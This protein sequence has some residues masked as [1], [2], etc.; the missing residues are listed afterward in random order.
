MLQST[1]CCEKCKVAFPVSD[2]CF[3]DQLIINGIGFVKDFLAAET[4]IS[5]ATWAGSMLKKLP[6]YHDRLVMH[7]PLITPFGGPS[8][9]I[10][11]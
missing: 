4:A 7:S 8:N 6:D 5:G 3:Y 11:L 2:R 1:N 9:R 10:Y